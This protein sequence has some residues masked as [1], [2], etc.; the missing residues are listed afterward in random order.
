MQSWP[1]DQHLRLA[2]TGCSSPAPYDQII[3]GELE[4]WHVMALRAFGSASS[5]IPLVARA[6][7]WA[8]RQLGR[9]NG[10]FL[11]DTTGITAVDWQNGA[12]SFI[13]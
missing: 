3:S 10:R 1:D 9:R 12:V 13:K 11:A 5:R 4:P 8:S 2:C 7:S 6:T